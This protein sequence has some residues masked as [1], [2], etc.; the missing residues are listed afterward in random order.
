MLKNGFT[1]IELVMVIVILGIL[2]A[3]ALPKFANLERDANIATLKS[4]QGSAHSAIALAHAK[5][6]IEGKE[7]LRDSTISIP[8]A[9]IMVDIGLRYGYPSENGLHLFA[10]I[11]DYFVRK[12]DYSD[13]G[14]ASYF[15][16]KGIT[17]CRFHY[18]DGTAT[19][20]ATLSRNDPDDIAGC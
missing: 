12:P 20:S 10:G 16:Y 11:H 2:S 17:D 4:A 13:F 7:T 18:K 1:L 8:F 9:G 15:L 6:V 19:T 5:A 14:N 3:V